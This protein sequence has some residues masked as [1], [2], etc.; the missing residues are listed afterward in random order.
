MT[1]YGVCWPP[2]PTDCIAFHNPGAAKAASPTIV[3]LKKTPRRQLYVVSSVS[4][5]AVS[6]GTVLCTR[7]SRFLVSGILRTSEKSF[8][9][10]EFENCTEREATMIFANPTREIKACRPISAER[11][12]CRKYHNENIN[13]AWV[14][15]R[16]DGATYTRPIDRRSWPTTVEKRR[17]CDIRLPIPWKCH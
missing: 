14:I 2:A 1:R 11:S 5:S 10:H 8:Q 16:C 15:Q 9:C 6:G 12:P 3:A 17:H 7:L 13:E 4:S